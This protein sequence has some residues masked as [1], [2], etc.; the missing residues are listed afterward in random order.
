MKE[1]GSNDPTSLR[2]VL[3]IVYFPRAAAF[4]ALSGFLVPSP[5]READSIFSCDAQSWSSA[6]AFQYAF[7]SIPWE[8]NATTVNGIRHFG[9]FRRTAR[10]DPL[11]A[12]SNCSFIVCDTP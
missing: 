10:A 7:A 3:W 6:L 5:E 8:M 12:I 4:E 9:Q 11:L 1:A 2:I